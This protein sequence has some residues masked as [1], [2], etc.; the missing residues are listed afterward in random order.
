MKENIERSGSDAAFDGSDAELKN[1]G[2]GKPFFI[3]G[4]DQFSPSVCNSLSDL[5]VTILT[6]SSPSRLLR[7]FPQNFVST[8]NQTRSKQYWLIKETLKVNIFGP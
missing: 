6:L 7:P 4:I 8:L 1:A 3:L 2:R 5:H